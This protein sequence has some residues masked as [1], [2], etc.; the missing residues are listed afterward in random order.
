MCLSYT[1]GFVAK[2]ESINNPLPKSFL[3]KSLKDFVGDLEEEYLLCPVRALSFYLHAT[4][5][6]SPRPNS[7]FVSPQCR[8]KAIS[9]NAVSSFL[10]ERISGAGALRVDGDRTLRA[11]SIRGVSTSMAFVRNWSV[12]QVLSAA[13]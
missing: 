10:R 8:Y 13:T 1:L 3:L 9:K 2:T 4:G 11:H 12:S 7:L 6:L 5:D